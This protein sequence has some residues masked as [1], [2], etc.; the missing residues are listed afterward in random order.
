MDRKH[1]ARWLRYFHRTKR[2]SYTGLDFGNMK[3]MLKRRNDIARKWAQAS[4]SRP[5]LE[6]GKLMYPEEREL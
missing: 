5:F 1:M 3:A 4:Y 2:L 6:N